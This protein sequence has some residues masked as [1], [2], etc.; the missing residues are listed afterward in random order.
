MDELLS[1]GVD[2][3]TTTT[4][5]VFGKLS[6]E[7]TASLFSVPRVCITGQRVVYQGDIRFTPYQSPLLIDGGEIRRM[8]AEDFAR[9]GVLPADTDTGAIIITGEAARK[10][11]A[12]V[13]AESLSGFAGEFV[14]ST[15][16]PALE[17]VLA[18]KGSGARQ[19]SRDNYCAAVNLDIGGGTTNIAMFVNG[20]AAATGCL[21]IGGRMVRL[22]PDG[23]VA[24][25]TQGA[26]RAAE[27]LDIPLSA[28]TAALLP[29][30]ERLAEK[31]GGLMAQ[32]LGF[33]PREPL[34]EQLRTAGCKPFAPPVP[35]G[36]VFFSGGVAR[37]IYGGEDEDW[38][39]YGDIGVLLG[40]AIARNKLLT[41][42]MAG[43]SETIRATVM[44]AGCYAT[45]VSGSTVAVDDT[46][47]PVKNL[48]VCH[49]SP[50]QEAQGVLEDP[51]LLAKEIVWLQEQC[52]RKDIAIGFC[53]RRDIGFRRLERLADSLCEAAENIPAEYP[54]IVAVE[55]DIA[56]ALGQA[57]LRRIGNR[58]G[59]VCIDGISTS[60]GDYIDLG[61]PLMGGLAVPVVIKTLLFG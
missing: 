6:V 26:L 4:Q 5:V 61:S 30:L 29:E 49:I 43:G 21:D 7:N 14:V 59:V 53:G 9:A 34:L 22:N 33:A 12:A 50:E 27:S 18:G 20:E 40:R 13:V 2:V 48:P 35:I 52:G 16:G 3:G 44:G 56:K 55:A 54:V 37:Y 45:T 39:K 19:Y 42:V 24:H 46:R 1:V 28:G 38:A 58:R 41:R 17:A 57:M 15:A 60:Q 23:A 31:L 51:G 32:E 8:V 36:R 47:F 25:A 11:N 10:E